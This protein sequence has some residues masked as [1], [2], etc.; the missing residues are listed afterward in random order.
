MNKVYI[1]AFSAISALG[2]GIEQSIKSLVNQ[3][4]LIYFPSI[5]EKFQ[6]PFF[7]IN[8]HLEVDQDKNRCSQ[9]ALSL[10]AFVKKDI[11]SLNNIPV[12]IAT[13]TGGI[14]ETEENYNGLIN[15]SVSYP[16][17]ERHFFNKIIEDINEVYNNKFNESY[18]FSTACSSS[19][20]TIM[21]AFEL[22]RNGIIDK[23]LVLGVD[24]LSLTTMVGFDSLKLISEKGTKPLCKD[25][26]G[27]SLGEGGGI[28]LLESNPH[29]DPVAEIVGCS[30]ST[31]GYHIS[32]P[33]PEG[34]Q[35]KASILKA[36]NASN[37]TPDSIDYINAHGTGTI[38]ND[39]ME[40][41]VIKSIFPK[42]TIVTSIKSFIGHT[43][44]ASAAVEVAIIL[45][46]LNQDTIFQPDNIGEPINEDYIPINTVKKE[47]KYFLKNSFGFGGNNVSMIFRMC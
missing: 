35:Q 2:I 21:Q 38:I 24:S 14:K 25:R 33:D 11:M 26:D 9:I 17:Y 34:T 41:D 5:N 40:M 7:K 16:L 1:T 36:L 4:Q 13:N 18:T 27:L 12:F 42:N 6:K 28:L 19:G 44:G 10:M 46:M 8:N 20:H 3:K 15:N 23:A 30:T 45:G 31:D 37:L 39:Q 43:L 22:I 29:I 47:V 32:S